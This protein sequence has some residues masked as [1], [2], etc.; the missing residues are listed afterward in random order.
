MLFTHRWNGMLRDSERERRWHPT[1]KPAALASWIMEKLTD[2][3]GIVLDPFSGGGWSIL[4][5][6]AS[7][8]KCRAIEMSADY[9]AVALERWSVATGKTPELING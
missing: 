6:E 3:G 4:G 5:A 7:G 1:Q 2:V 9:V 8:R